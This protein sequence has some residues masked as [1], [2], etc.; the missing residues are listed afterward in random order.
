MRKITRDDWNNLFGR[1]QDFI[2][3]VCYN[4]KD[5]VYY[6]NSPRDEGEDDDESA[7]VG[8]LIPVVGWPRDLEDVPF[9]LGDRYI[10]RDGLPHFI[11]EICIN[12]SRFTLVSLANMEY[13]SEVYSKGTRVQRY[14]EPVVDSL[15]KVLRDLQKESREVEENQLEELIEESIRRI[16][17][18]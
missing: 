6:Y 13:H 15:E 17:N 5:C 18:L 8:E 12:E 11:D 3:R 14:E 1:E 2:N 10:G 9:A 16:E 7:E 4:K